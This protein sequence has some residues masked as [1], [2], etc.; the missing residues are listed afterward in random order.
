MGTD[1]FWSFLNQVALPLHRHLSKYYCIKC[2]HVNNVTFVR[3]EKSSKGSCAAGIPSSWPSFL[4]AALVAPVMAA[5]PSLLVL[6]PAGI[7]RSV[8]ISTSF[9]RGWL[10]RFQPYHKHVSVSF[11]HTQR[12]A[13]RCLR[14]GGARRGGGGRAG[15]VVGERRGEFLLEFAKHPFFKDSKYHPLPPPSLWC[16]CNTTRRVY[17]KVVEQPKQWNLG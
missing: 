6:S 11:N 4:T 2:Y 7:V 12:R 14:G 9:Q 5:S 3:K 13:H 15:G 10:P 8:P 16:P 1:A 17:G